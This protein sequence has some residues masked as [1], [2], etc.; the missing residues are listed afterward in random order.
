[1]TVVRN[2]IIRGGGDFSNM[3]REL[4]NAQRNIKEFKAGVLGA[5]KGIGAALG[6]IKLIGFG[7]DATKMAMDVEAAMMTIDKQMGSSAQA[8]VDWAN[9]QAGAFN[10]SKANAISYGAIFGNLISSFS[11]TAQQTE[12][13]T[14][15]MLKASAVV[16]ESTG[17]TMTDVMWRIR[18][19]MMGNTEAIEDL[20]VNVYVNLLKST[21]AFKD[22]AGNKSWNQLDYKTK[23]LITYYGILEQVQKKFGTQVIGN[24]NTALMAL[25]AQLGNLKLALGQAFLPI[26]QRVLPIL[27]TLVSYLVQAADIVSQFFRALF[28]YNDPSAH[29]KPIAATAQKISSGFNNAGN[30]ATGAAKKMT[31]AAKAT[32]AALG[33]LMGFD[34]VNTLSE[35]G[36]SSGS[37][38]SSGGGGAGG[39]GAGGVGSGGAMG[40]MPKDPG[41][42]SAMSKISASVKAVADKIKATFRELESFLQKHKDIIIAICAGIAAGIVTAFVMVKWGAIVEGIAVLIDKLTKSMIFLWEAITGPV[43]IVVAAVALVVAAFVYFY[44]TNTAFRNVVNNIL[45]KIKEGLIFLWNKVLV[46]FGKWIGTVF[47]AAWNVISTAASSFYTNVLVPLGNYFLKFYNQIIKPAGEWMSD[48]FKP[49]WSALGEI[50]KVVWKDAFVPLGGYFSKTFGPA[51]EALSTVLTFLWNKVTVPIA[52]FIGDT[53][54]T[55]FKNWG[56]IIGDVWDKMSPFASWLYKNFLTTIKDVFGGAKGYIDHMGD[57]MASLM[58]FIT[59][60]FQGKWGKA[61]ID[62]KSSFTSVWKGI[63]SLMAG[64]LNVFIDG[65]NKIIGAL[66]SVS[67]KIPDWV[68]GAGGKTFGVHIPTM[69]RLARGGITNGPMAA[70]VGDNP[71]GREVVSPL[72][73]LQDIVAGAVSTGVINAMKFSQV[74]G[75][76]GGDVV[77]NI[78]GRKFA[79]VI[80]PYLQRENTRLGTSRIKQ[81]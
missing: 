50:V 48:K 53:V 65:F 69:Q 18:S 77:I 6:G 64:I 46:P 3:R 72:S 49:I 61:W 17:R 5:V 14:V 20:G 10:L 38:G 68:P 33:G 76:K 34:E 74:G 21:Q 78:D 40:G 56:K 25:E 62:I 66:N 81:L 67:F 73:D 32:K 63:G 45:E 52:K 51:V 26:V 43:G 19:G 35:K 22:F 59:D 15:D 7:E 79:K 47:L 31:S 54:L 30:A 80:N 37:G 75:N 55:I 1:M 36:G 16:A 29:L 57:A 24:T 60:V 71:G 70:I 9:T 42:A 11:D 39:V 8:F 58:K 41:H 28:G 2:L 23:Q 4:Q 12:S 27:T 44:R 13:R